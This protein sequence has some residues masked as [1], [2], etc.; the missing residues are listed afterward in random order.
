MEPTPTEP[1]SGNPEAEK[2]QASEEAVPRQQAA[3]V[4]PA[5]YVAPDERAEIPPQES[6]M[7]QIETR[8]DV[9]KV[10]K[11]PELMESEDRSE[12]SEVKS[13]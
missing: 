3:D 7:V 4:A 6:K 13:R 1:A 9:V 12:S 10:D 2:H 5:P 8:P 11:P